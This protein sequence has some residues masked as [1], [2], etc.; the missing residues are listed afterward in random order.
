MTIYPPWEFV[1]FQIDGAA[2]ITDDSPDYSA[3]VKAR[4]LF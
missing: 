2:G 4:F 1:S 3:E